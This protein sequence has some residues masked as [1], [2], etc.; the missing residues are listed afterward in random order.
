MKN[1]RNSRFF[2]TQLMKLEIFFLWLVDLFLDFFLQ[3]M[4]GICNLF[5]KINFRNSLFFLGNRINSRFFFSAI[6][7]WNLYFFPR[8]NYCKDQLKE[9]AI[10]FQRPI[11]EIH[12]I[13]YAPDWRNSR[14]C[15]QS[16]VEIWKF[17][18]PRSNSW[19]SR[20]FSTQ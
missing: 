8:Q 2:W 6:D 3:Q 1:C 4:E 12:D 18:F 15:L 16:M 7:R 20:F 17:F 19:N 13:I 11:D 14:L 9:F 5:A 10:F